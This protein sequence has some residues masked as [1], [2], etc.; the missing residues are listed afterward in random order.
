MK[1][2]ESGYKLDLHIHSCYS[3]AKDRAKVAFNT[4]DNINILAQKLSEN[5]VQLCAITDH[6]AFNFDIY[7][8]LKA[9]KKSLISL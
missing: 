7:K 3:S 6:D 9:Y 2:V 8:A 5:E 1:I 4:I